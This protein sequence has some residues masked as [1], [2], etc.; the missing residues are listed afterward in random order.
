MVDLVEGYELETMS[1]TSERAD[2]SFIVICLNKKYVFI[3]ILRSILP[4]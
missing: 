2:I 4:I 3:L 1:A